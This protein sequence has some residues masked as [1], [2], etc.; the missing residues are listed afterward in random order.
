VLA[1]FLGV[2]TKKNGNQDS[3]LISRS[4]AAKA[5]PFCLIKKGEKIKVRLRHCPSGTAP[6]SSRHFAP[7][8]LLFLAML[9]SEPAH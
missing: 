8:L 2:V 5:S 7:C 4:M 6:K 9:E 1:A 3:F